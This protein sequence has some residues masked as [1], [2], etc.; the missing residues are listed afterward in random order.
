[1]NMTNF[2]QT[3]LQRFQE[4]LQ[5]ATDEA[6]IRGMDVPIELMAKRLFKAADQ[7][8]RDVDRLKAV[9]LGEEAWP[10]TGPAGKGPAIDPLTLATRT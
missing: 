2:T 8:L 3:D 5:A 6:A 1:M 9:A 10:P 4:I 7:G